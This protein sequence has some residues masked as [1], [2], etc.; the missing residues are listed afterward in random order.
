MRFTFL[1]AW[2][3]YAENAKTK[4]FWIGLCMFPLIIFISVKASVLL[5]TKGTPTRYYILVDQSG[6][7]A[8]AVESR[9]DRLKPH[10]K[11]GTPPS[12]APSRPFQPATLPAMIDTNADLASL[13]RELKPYLRREKKVEADG[14]EVELSAAI[15]I[16]RDIEKQIV[17]PRAKSG[18]AN[19]VG[20][21]IEY[22]SG[23]LA[24]TKLRDEIEQS[25]NEEIRRREYVARGLD[26]A[27]IR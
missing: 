15:L 21:G 5:Q 27:A 10:L 16:P 14:R 11:P 13:A 23:N 22:W 9:L 8:S 19:A 12:L 26:S 25:V 6:K 20:N 17:R 1:V 7:F 3:E 24:D 18:P 4:G 2:R